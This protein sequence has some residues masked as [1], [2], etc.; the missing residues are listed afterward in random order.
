MNSFISTT[1]SFLDILKLYHWSTKSYPRHMASD[2]AH[3]DFQAL[4][5]QFVEVYIGKYGRN[6]ILSRISTKSVSVVSDKEILKHISKMIYYLSN[7]PLTK[8]DIDLYTIR[9]EMVAVLNQTLY[10]FSLS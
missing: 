6:R 3:K 8:N 4:N 5:D 2:K 9:D 10:L 7:I 1:L